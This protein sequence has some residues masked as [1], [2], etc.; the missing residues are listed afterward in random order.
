V[1]RFI[2]RKYFPALKMKLSYANV[3]QSSMDA[4][5]PS[6]STARSAVMSRSAPLRGFLLPLAACASAAACCISVV[7]TSVR[8]TQLIFFPSGSVPASRR[9]SSACAAHTCT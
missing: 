1:E 9:A 3:A 8:C 6:F 5:L 4:A 7:S 2:L